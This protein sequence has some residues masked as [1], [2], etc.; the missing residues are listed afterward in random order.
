MTKEKTGHDVLDGADERRPA[1]RRPKENSERRIKASGL[2]D[3]P[4]WTCGGLPRATTKG[5][6]EAEVKGFDYYNTRN[7]NHRFRA[8]TAEMMFSM[9]LL[10]HGLRRAQSLY[11]AGVLSIARC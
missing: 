1:Y 10:R 8:Y 5:K 9:W 3:D 2:S 7:W 6:W 4:M 11:A